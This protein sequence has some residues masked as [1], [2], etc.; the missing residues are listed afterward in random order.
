MI[1]I[2]DM[3]ATLIDSNYA[4]TKTINDKRA[5]FG[6][7]ELGAKFILNTINNPSKNAFAELFPNIDFSKDEKAKFESDFNKSYLEHAQ[8]YKEAL[9]VVN[10]ALEQDFMLAVASN[11]PIK[12]INKVLESVKIKDK[13]SFIVGV[14]SDTPPKPDPKMLN[15]IMQNT[16][17]IGIFIGD[18]NKDYFAAKNAN[19]PY[20]NVLW[21]RDDEIEGVKNCK[22]A[23]EVILEIERIRGKF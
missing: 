6:L 5:F 3:D 17:K 1:I 15:L 10:W 14:D 23:S 7:D 9:D 13:F 4:I 11:A 16:D 19:L 8:I 12:T 21:G 18:S 20:I 2:F 22:F